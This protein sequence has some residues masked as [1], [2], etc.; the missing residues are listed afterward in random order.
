MV[1]NGNPKEAGIYKSYREPTI[2]INKRTASGSWGCGGVMVRLLASHQGAVN[3][4]VLHVGIVQDDTAGRRVYSGISRFLSSFIPALL[5]THLTSSSASILKT[6]MP[7]ATQISSRYH[8]LVHNNWSAD[9]ESILSPKDNADFAHL[10]SSKFPLSHIHQAK[11][12]PLT[13]RVHFPTVQPASLEI[14][15]QDGRRNSLAGH[16]ASSPFVP[17]E[18]LGT[19]GRPQLQTLGTEARCG[20]HSL[21]APTQKVLRTLRLVEVNVG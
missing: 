21:V 3:P 1:L 7:R 8:Y 11:R 12:L 13:H 16:T 10:L 15:S 2:I 14:C 18:Y 9:L 6:S 5:H 4:G 17:M 20:L 19:N